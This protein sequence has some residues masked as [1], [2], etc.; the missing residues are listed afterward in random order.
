M[1]VL[2][3]WMLLQEL[4]GIVSGRT[5]NSSESLMDG[6]KR[7]QAA[8]AA[9]AEAA[10]EAAAKS[11]NQLIGSAQS[12]AMP[13][14]AESAPKPSLAASSNPFAGLFG[15]KTPLAPPPKKD[16]LSESGSPIPVIPL[17]LCDCGLSAANAQA[18]FACMHALRSCRWVFWGV[19][20]E[21]NRVFANHRDS[22]EWSH[23]PC[24]MLSESV[25]PAAVTSLRSG[26][27]AERVCSA[28]DGII[29]KGTG[30]KSVALCGRGMCC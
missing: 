20:L 5:S 26:R 30:A 23:Y 22:C 6:F 27:Q 4:K 17:A 10:K 19:E 24:T 3:S 16:P 8:A 9:A 1:R 21:L 7:T 11:T 12:A 2:G 28:L 29:I 18:C 25:P 14:L 15:G 13:S